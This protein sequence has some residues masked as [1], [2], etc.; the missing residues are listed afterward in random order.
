MA[1]SAVSER[2][3]AAED[4]SDE[5][6]PHWHSPLVFQPGWFQRRT[7]Q[8]TYAVITGC[9]ALTFMRN[10]DH[11]VSGVCGLSSTFPILSAS[12]LMYKPQYQLWILTL[13]VVTVGR[14]FE[15]RF[16]RIFASFT[17]LIR[18]GHRSSLCEGFTSRPRPLR[19][20]RP[21]QTM[22]TTC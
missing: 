11:A 18:F 17:V 13:F 1:S 20:L 19:R 10:Y 2:T 15:V 14:V 21:P 7:G 12:L 16:C 6:L 5:P 3:A 9:M 22:R 8:L 4:T